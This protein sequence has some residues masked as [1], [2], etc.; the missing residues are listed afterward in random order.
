MNLK[1][2]SRRLIESVKDVIGPKGKQKLIIRNED[3]GVH[4][5]SKG[6]RIIESMEM[7]HPV[8][9]MIR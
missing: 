6:S 2:V 9:P 5:T 3:G 4:C 7:N 1:E 8:L